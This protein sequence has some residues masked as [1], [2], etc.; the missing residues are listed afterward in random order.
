MPPTSAEA[1]EPIVLWETSVTSPHGSERVSKVRKWF[2]AAGT[3]SGGDKPRVLPAGI[4]TLLRAAHP[5]RSIVC[6]LCWPDKL[7][8][9]GSTPLASNL[10]EDAKR[11]SSAG[12]TVRVAVVEIEGLRALG[13]LV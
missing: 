4:V 13:V 9:A 2:R 5:G 12:A 3:L 8:A 11:A 10:A 1:S 7:L 6:A